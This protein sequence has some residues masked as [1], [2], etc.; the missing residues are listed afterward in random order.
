[1]LNL[2]L[3]RPALTSRNSSPGKSK[4]DDTISDL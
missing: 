1:M 4:K 2:K 3:K